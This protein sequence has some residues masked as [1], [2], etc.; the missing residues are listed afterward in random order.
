M[1]ESANLE[2]ASPDTTES[3]PP[4]SF[5]QRLQEDL[6]DEGRSGI[7]MADAN[8]ANSSVQEDQE[9]GGWG[10]SSTAA[11]GRPTPQLPAVNQFK[12]PHAHPTQPP[13]S[14]SAFR[15]YVLADQYS[16]DELQQV[17]HQ[18]LLENLTPAKAMSLLFA[19]YR[20][21]EL[22]NTVTVWVQTNWDAVKK[23]VS[24]AACDERRASQT[25]L[26]L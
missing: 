2:E 25:S 20:Y 5:S 19:S 15:T 4:G 14:A 21:K 10:T 8:H 3:S 7:E 12:D 18:A 23:D 6:S 11:Q 17:T 24:N 13:P 26:T 22:H 16:L 1:D 9:I